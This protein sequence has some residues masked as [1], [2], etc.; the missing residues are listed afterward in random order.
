[1]LRSQAFDSPSVFLCVLCAPALA[2]EPV[3][4]AS[5][6]AAEL[7]V[8]LPSELPQPHQRHLDLRRPR[9]PAA[10]ADAVAIALGGGEH[11]AR[12]NADTLIARATEQFER[13]H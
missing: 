4:S 1:M 5:A 6:S 3:L 10:D 2:I 11:R 7:V 8:K 9:V 12:R 13:I